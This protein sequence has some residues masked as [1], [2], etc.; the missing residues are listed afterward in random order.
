MPG[1]KGNPDFFPKEPLYFYDMTEIP[2]MDNLFNPTSVLL[3]LQERIAK[4]Y[5]AEN[6]IICTNGSTGGVLSSIIYAAKRDTD[7]I[8]AR[9]C[10]RSAYSGVFLTGANP[11]YIY[12]EMTDFGVFGGVL[13]E[14]VETAIIEHPEATAVMITSPTFEGF[15]SDVKAISEITKRYQKILIV[16]EAHGS[17]CAF[18]K[19]FP[20]PATAYADIVI[21]SLHKSLPA[22]GQLSCLLLGENTD[23]KR[24]RDCMS[25]IH[26]S[27]PSYVIMSQCDYL[28]DKITDKKLWDDYISRLKEFRKNCEKLDNIK[29]IGNNYRDKYG[30]CDVDISRL[31]FLPNMSGK[32]FYNVLVNEKIQLE[33]FG[34]IY[35]VGISS[36]ADT[37][38]SF[39]RLYEALK[40][41]D[42]LPIYNAQDASSNPHYKNFP[43]TAH[44]SRLTLA[45]ALQTKGAKVKM[46]N[47]SGLISRKFIIPYPPGVPLL[48]PGEEITDEALLYLQSCLS[49]GCETL[50]ISVEADSVFLDVC[51][52]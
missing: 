35:A 31:V 23:V 16:D 24:L 46:E 8:I 9:N 47:C 20:K 10:H 2:G 17:H 48:S 52:N 36:C 18:S 49:A 19:S 45:G 27:S 50:G 5:G 34:Q 29:L 25:F 21:T 32:E 44:N 41:A 40:I 1:H 13:P 33:Y 37:K 14:T 43:K 12:P 22:M 3:K 4:A 42:N 28:F 39:S 51:S 15:T 7:I 30:I 11:C 6:S 38:K 26:T